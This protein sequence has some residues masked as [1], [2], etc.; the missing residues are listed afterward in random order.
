LVK[1]IDGGNKEGEKVE[2][3]SLNGRGNFRKNGGV[4]WEISLGG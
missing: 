4:L 1:V 2:E 3:P